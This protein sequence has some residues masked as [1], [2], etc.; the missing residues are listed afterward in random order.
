MEESR[1]DRI[2]TEEQGNLFE[3]RLTSVYRT[4]HTA[5]WEVKPPAPQLL[6]FFVVVMKKMGSFA[7][8]KTP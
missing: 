6:V 7:E 3:I 8:L 4:A 2:W 5:V 1:E